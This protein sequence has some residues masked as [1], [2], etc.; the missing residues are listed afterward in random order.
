MRLSAARRTIW[1]RVL[2]RASRVVRY[3]SSER[4]LAL[5]VSKLLEER[6]GDDLRVRKPLERFVASS[7][8]AEQ[9]VSVVDEAKEDGKGFFRAGEV[10]GMVRLGHLLLLCE[11]RL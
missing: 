9:R 7:T 1:A 11:G 5:H 3:I 6:E 4:A 10:W 2:S 8:G